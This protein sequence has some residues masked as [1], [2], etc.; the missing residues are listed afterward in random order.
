[1]PGNETYNGLPFTTSSDVIN[2]SGTGTPAISS[3]DEAYGRVAEVQI[4]QQAFGRCRPEA[5]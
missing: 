2:T 3:A 4:A 5:S 1:M